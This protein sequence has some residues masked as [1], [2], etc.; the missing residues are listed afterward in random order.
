MCIE[1]LSSKHAMHKPRNQ[2]SSKEK[3]RHREL[4]FMDRSVMQDILILLGKF[5]TSMP[6]IFVTSM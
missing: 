2:K 1:K 6:D 4:F 5:G 3:W